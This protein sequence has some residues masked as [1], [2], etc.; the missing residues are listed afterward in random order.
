[1]SLS[2][3]HTQTYTR[4]FSE[5]EGTLSARSSFASG[6]SPPPPTFWHGP[7]LRVRFL[8]ASHRFSL[9]A[10]LSRRFRRQSP[11]VRPESAP[12]VCPSP[13]IA[14]PTNPRPRDIHLRSAG[15]GGGDARRV[16]TAAAPHPGSLGGPGYRSYHGRA[17]AGRPPRSLP[18][19][20]SPPL[21]CPN[22]CA[23]ATVSG[24]V[25]SAEGERGGRGAEGAR[26]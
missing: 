24:G 14:A 20:G 25:Q 22:S 21:T 5:A 4:S 3:L 16:A 10:E 2:T 19:Q 23:G 15:S 12:S 1:M 11:E 26:R 8:S 13:I 7:A 6:D 9:H 18:S 17:S